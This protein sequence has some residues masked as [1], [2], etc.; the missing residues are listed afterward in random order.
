MNGE[1]MP[2]PDP[3]AAVSDLRLSVYLRA[4]HPEFF[5]IR[6]ARPFEQV[7]FDGQ[8][9]LIDGGHVVTFIDGSDAVTEVIGP[10]EL[11][12]PKRGLAR[13]EDLS[14]GREHRIDARGALV[15]R[16]V[17]QVEACSAETYVRQAEELLASARRGHLYNEGTAADAARAFSYAVAEPKGRGLLLHTWHGFPAECTI[18]RTQTLIERT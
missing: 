5:D 14:A 2:G 7:A 9:W 6:A 17:Y 11:E 16:M 10:K 15:Y 13:A 1:P 12:L 18:L 3:Q 4:L 8:L